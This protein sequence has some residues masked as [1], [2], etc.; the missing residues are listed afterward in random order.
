MFKIF[1]EFV[2][3]L[4]LPLCFGFG[5]ASHVGSYL[6]NQGSNPASLAL[7]GEVLTTGPPETSLL[8][9]FQGPTENLPNMHASPFPDFSSTYH[10]PSTSTT[11]LSQV[12]QKQTQ[13][14]RLTCQQFI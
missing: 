13:R 3:T 6:P 7:E 12:P 4:L 5:A 8:N 1:I 14:Y 9:D 2:T 11:D 10:L